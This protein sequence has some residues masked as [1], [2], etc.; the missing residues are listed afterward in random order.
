MTDPTIKD[1]A[2]AAHTSAAEDLEG[3]ALRM[4]P[5][6]RPAPESTAAAQQQAADQSVAPATPADRLDAEMQAVRDDPAHRM[7]S[8]SAAARA[9][10]D[11]IFDGA[12]GQTIEIDGQPVQIDRDL[13]TKSVMALREMAAD[14]NLSD[15]DMVGVT[16]GLTFAQSIRGDPEK[17]I[18]ARESAVEM[19]NAE[20]GQEAALAARAARAYVAKNPK[21]G[22]LLDRTGAGDSPQTIALIARRALSLHKA[23]KLT[24]TAAPARE[25]QGI[26]GQRLFAA[27]NMNP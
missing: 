6:M 5:S 7:F 15:R 8:V 16:E 12:I 21:L 9:V 14:L 4:F 24:V 17:A 1:E 25:S 23:G 20:H 10:P 18:A 11:T 19:L 3:V 26:S 13:A 27:S 2:E 22:A